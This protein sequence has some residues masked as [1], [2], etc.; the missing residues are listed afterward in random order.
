M[1]FDIFCEKLF[2]RLKWEQIS[3]DKK[4]NNLDFVELMKKII[5][6]SNALCQGDLTSGNMPL[7]QTTFDLLTFLLCVTLTL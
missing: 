5:Y 1:F 4:K 3:L 6:P 7:P 2:S